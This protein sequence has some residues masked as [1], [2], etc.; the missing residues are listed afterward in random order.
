VDS[1]LLHHEVQNVG[2]NK[3]NAMTLEKAL[4]NEEWLIKK[5]KNQ[6][7]DIIIATTAINQEVSARSV[8][9]IQIITGLKIENLAVKRFRKIGC[10]ISLIVFHQFN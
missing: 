6:L 9:D 8:G 2:C 7:P 4:K 5:Y 3:I 1:V 10:S